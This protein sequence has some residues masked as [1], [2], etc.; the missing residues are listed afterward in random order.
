M[1]YVTYIL[2]TNRG[3]R[4]QPTNGLKDKMEHCFSSIFL[5][6]SL[7]HLMIFQ[8]FVV[9]P[10]WKII[11][12]DK[13]IAIKPHFSTVVSGI[14]SIYIIIIINLLDIKRKLQNGQTILLFCHR[15]SS[16]TQ[17]VKQIAWPTKTIFSHKILIFPF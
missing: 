8:S 7:A 1:Q 13:K 4:N 15:V 5:H 6:K 14:Q 10:L 3:T 17:A 12:Y 11:K 9:F 2:V 16:K